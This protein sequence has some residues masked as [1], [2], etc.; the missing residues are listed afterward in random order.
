MDSVNFIEWKPPVEFIVISSISIN[1]LAF[2][3]LPVSTKS[4]ILRHKLIFGAISIAPLSFI[5]SA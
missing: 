5:H 2:R 1:P 4:T 3:V